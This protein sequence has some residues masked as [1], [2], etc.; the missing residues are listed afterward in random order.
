LKRVTTGLAFQLQR[1][2]FCCFGE[3]SLKRPFSVPAIS[4]L[5]AVV[6]SLALRQGASFSSLVYGDCVRRLRLAFRTVRGDFFGRF[7]V[8]FHFADSVYNNQLKHIKII[9]KCWL[10]WNLR[11]D[12]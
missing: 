2:L 10:G 7:H 9:I 8:A 6:L 4:L 1:L 11:R 5:Y 12:F 3:F